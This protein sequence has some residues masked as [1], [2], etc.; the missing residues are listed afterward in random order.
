MNTTFNFWVN[1]RANAKGCFD[2]YIRITQDRKHKLTKTGIAVSNRKD[3]NPK[4]KQNNWI[5]GKAASTA[6]LNDILAFQLEAVKDDKANLQRKVK[7]PSKEVILQKYRGESSQDFLSFLRLIIDRFNQSG[8]YRT[9]KRYNQLLN[10]LI[11]FEADKIPFDQI[12]VTFLKNFNSYLSEL[13][14]NT[15]Y[16]HFKNMKAAF[17]QAIQ[18]DV[19]DSDQNPFLRFKVKK[20]PTNKPKLTIEEI[21]KLEALDLKDNPA[22][23]HT[24]NCFLFSFYCGGIRAGDLIMMR[25]QNVQEGKLCYVMAKNRNSKLTERSIPLLTEATKILKHYKTQDFSPDH[26]IFGELE[27][28]L[29]NFISH[30]NRI[31]PG[32]EIRIYNRIASRNTI[33]NK[34]LKKLAVLAGITKQLTFHISRHSFAQYAINQDMN[35]KMLQTILG[36]TKFATTEAYINT[37]QDKKVSEE[38]ERIFS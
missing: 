5:R 21:H 22:L 4:A 16:E 19:I 32:H 36:H 14:Q 6:K 12:T 31:I 24:R 18:E 30:D 8:A 1:N 29:T 3:F 35:P 11:E 15:R 33:L 23:D 17:N 27:N 34:N 2:I 38:M 10:K 13:H 26:F 25:W 7:N 20:V 37:L 9:S 28:T